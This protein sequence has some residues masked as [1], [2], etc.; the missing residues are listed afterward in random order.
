MF[1]KHKQLIAGLVMGGVIASAGAAFADG[2]VHFV[3]FKFKFD[4]VEKS[5]PEGFTVL[6]YN[7]R[8][9][10]PARFVAENLGAKVD[11][12]GST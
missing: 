3:N 10:V 9:Y 7:G 12:D 1:R 11:W 6:E 5:L 8:T 4:G 2:P